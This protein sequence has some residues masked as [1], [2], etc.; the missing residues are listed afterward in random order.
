M[1]H[2][3]II[4][5]SLLITSSAQSR[6]L[7]K[8]CDDMAKDIGKDWYLENVL[9][10]FLTVINRTKIK[11]INFNFISFKDDVPHDGINIETAQGNFP[12]CFERA[13]TPTIILIEKKDLYNPFDQKTERHLYFSILTTVH[14]GAPCLGS[15]VYSVSF[16][17]K[18]SKAS[19][20]WT[21]PTTGSFWGLTISENEYPSM[22]FIDHL[23]FKEAYSLVPKGEKLY[24][25]DKWY[26][27]D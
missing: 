14:C 19:S 6:E 4:L 16:R 10:E 25:R 7:A 21:L 5:L 27:V 23:T 12:L 2:F 9:P 22:W 24:W 11:D 1:K 26:E 13:A 15:H 8:H 17:L 20:S 3:F 18:S